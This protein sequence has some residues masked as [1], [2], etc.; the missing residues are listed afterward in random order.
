[1]KTE[2][3]K[4][5]P[6]EARQKE[7]AL[8]LDVRTPAEHG[9]THIEGSLLHPLHQLDADQIKEHLTDG[10]TCIII[11]R[12]G[13]RAGQAAEKLA[14]A[15]VENL[16]VLDGGIEAWENANLPVNKGKGGI[17]LQRQVLM[18]AGFFVLTGSLLGI[19][20]HPG[21]LFVPTFFGAGLLF[22]GITNTCGL[23]MVLARMP[24][25]Q[26]GGAAPKSCSV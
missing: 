13:N 26:Q 23:A 16:H 21:F 15:G 24:W 4:I 25:N 5:S 10:K 2:I 19:F 9:A 8:W 11:C 6:T 12:T 7:N 18:T 17:S 20:I 14:E 22:A 3:S 1:M